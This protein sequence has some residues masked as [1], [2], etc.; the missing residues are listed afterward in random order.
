[1]IVML[2]EGCDLGFEV[3]LEEV[4]FEQDAVLER[5]VPTFDFPLRLRMPGS[6]MDLLD[7]VFLRA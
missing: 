3:L 7:L 4:I 5:L 2:D 6:A 1:M